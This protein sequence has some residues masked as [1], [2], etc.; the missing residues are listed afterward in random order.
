MAYIVPDFTSAMKKN[1]AYEKDYGQY[2]N[3]QY[4]TWTGAEGDRAALFRGT[5]PSYSA[6]EHFKSAQY[7]GYY[8][9]L[10]STALQGKGR[11]IYDRVQLTGKEDYDTSGRNETEYPLVSMT[12][13]GL[14]S[15]DVLVA[16]GV[17]TCAVGFIMFSRR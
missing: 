2:K 7:N 10:V 16:A 12:P 5:Y 17:F 1:L 3:V 14:N 13:T 15:T 11:T 4:P 6:R 8:R 9:N